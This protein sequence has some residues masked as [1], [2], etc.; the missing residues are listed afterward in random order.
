MVRPREAGAGW[1]RNGKV[2]ADDTEA[3]AAAVST[4][5]AGSHLVVPSHKPQAAVGSTV[6]GN[7]GG[8]GLFAR[9]TVGDGR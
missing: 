4:G 8:W 3:M 6:W 5:P 9:S 2:V 7:F 1:S